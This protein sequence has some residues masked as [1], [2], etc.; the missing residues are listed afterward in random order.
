M[1]VLQIQQIVILIKYQLIKMNKKIL[2]GMV[3]V[4]LLISGCNKTDNFD[5]ENEKILEKALELEEISVNKVDINKD[6]IFVSIE[7]SDANEH[8]NQ[9]IEWWGGIFGLTTLMKGDYMFVIIENTVNG[10]PYT[11][12]SSNIYSIKDFSEFIITDVEFFEESLVTSDIPKSKQ[13]LQAANLPL[14]TLSDEKNFKMGMKFE[15]AGYDLSFLTKYLIYSGIIIIVILLVLLGFKKKHKV[16]HYYSKTKKHRQKLHK[17]YKETIVPKTM[18]LSKNTKKHAIILSNKTK[19]A[20]NEKIAPKAK[21]LAKKAKKKT[22]ELMEKTK[23]Y[24]AEET[25]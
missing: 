11:Y 18:E 8:D 21:E 20:Y 23:N 22:K 7:V 10:E 14:D 19:K 24:S 2:F 12:V 17:V 25:K 16:K 13:I 9:L 4:L 5:K 6:T 1:I 3:I 15:I